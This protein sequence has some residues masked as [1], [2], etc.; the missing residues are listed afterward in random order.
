MQKLPQNEET[1]YWTISIPYD[2][3]L[4]ARVKRLAGAKWLAQERCWKIS[5][6]ESNA[7]L[8]HELQLIDY[9]T[10]G[11]IVARPVPELPEIANFPI[12][13]TGQPRPA[14]DSSDIDRRSAVAFAPSD[15]PGVSTSGDIGAMHRP[16]AEVDIERKGKWLCV[17]MAYSVTEAA[18]LRSL[19]QSWWHKGDKV[20]VLPA[21]PAIL[22]SLHER[23]GV[24]SAET[25]QTWL[26]L[27]RQCEDPVV[28]T[29]Y[30]SPEFPGDLL[31]KVKGYGADQAWL[32]SLPDRQYDRAAQRWQVP[33]RP[34]LAERIKE[35][36]ER[37]GDQVIDRISVENAQSTKRRKAA[38]PGEQD[39]LLSKFSLLLRPQ[40]EAF[41][42]A[43]LR[44]HYSR[45]TIK[46]YTTWYARYL[47]V[48]ERIT[49]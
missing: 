46:Q 2:L 5:A 6:T 13:T 33:K 32:K 30:E 4:I 24:P 43:L 18:F 44:M 10:T 48:E 28:I 22:T 29:L 34:G 17:R 20:W 49:I 19:P 47:V 38:E 1:L 26:E 27:L 9:L 12:G 45:S 42:D 31:I 21:R 16:I 39:H 14:G 41:T 36:Y 15:V 7:A 25:Y 37:R 40:L 35:Y 23:Y 8:L 11:Q 3:A